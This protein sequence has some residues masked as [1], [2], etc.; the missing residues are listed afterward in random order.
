MEKLKKDDRKE[1][2]KSY[3]LKNREKRLEYQKEYNKKN[4]EK[5]KLYNIQ[6]Y[7]KKE[8]EKKDKIY[9]SQDK[10]IVKF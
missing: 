2:K 10:F 4:K 5:I 7:Q 1:E 9:I 8:Q 6:Y 3:Y